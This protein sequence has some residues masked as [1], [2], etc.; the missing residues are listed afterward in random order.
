MGDGNYLLFDIAVSVVWEV[1]Y[2][3][4]TGNMDY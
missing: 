4:P 3:Y 2:A 1:K